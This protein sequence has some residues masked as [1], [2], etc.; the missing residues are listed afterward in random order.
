MITMFNRKELISTYDMGQQA[1]VRNI[2][3]RNH[4]D[5][6][7][8]TLN[9]KSPSPFGAGSRAYTGTFGEKLESELEYTI[10]VKKEDYDTACLLIRN[11][12]L[13]K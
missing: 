2:L 9:R 13:G 11:I 12:N 10:Y 7:V 3:S 4:I 6:D 1:E 5:Y 8:K